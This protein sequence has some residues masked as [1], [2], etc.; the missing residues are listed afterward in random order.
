[1][2]SLS[3][4]LRTLSLALAASIA[5]AGTA[6]AAERAFQ[7]QTSEDE[8][9]GTRFV[10]QG[11]FE[12]GADRLKLALELAGTARMM[13]APV[14][15][16]LCV[17]YTMENRLDEANGYCND[18]VSNGRELGLAFNNRG[19]LNIA[20]GD[21]HA[22]IADFETAVN[23][24]GASQ[25]AQ[26]NLQLARELVASQADDNGVPHRFYGSATTT[27]PVKAGRS[28]F[29]LSPKDLCARWSGAFFL[30]RQ[31]ARPAPDVGIVT[32][33]AAQAEPDVSAARRQS[34][35]PDALRHPWPDRR[36]RPVL[37]VFCRGWVPIRCW[38]ARSARWA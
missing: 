28:R 38:P 4:T 21:L 18:Y 23:K 36:Q 25:I 30:R 34:P 7:L 19:V 37:G 10:E 11:A 26:Q 29:R 17:A 27:T 2:N 15:N 14:L 6:A 35:L 5:L 33:L 1:M 22:A 20:R 8:V 3:T 16:N 9:Y 13:R 24:H 31:T 32:L 12:E